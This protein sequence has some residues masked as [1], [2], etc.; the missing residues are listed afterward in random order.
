MDRRTEISDHFMHAGA[1][2]SMVFAWLGLIP[3]VIPLVALTAVLVAV[4]AL[5]LAALGLVAVVIAGPP[6]AGWRL[7]RRLGF[8]GGGSPVRV[9]EFEEIAEAHR[10]MESS[11]A[12]G[13]LVIRGA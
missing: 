3:G 2:T 13:K 7:V 10:V 12:A 1:G 9:F 11:Q 6:Y 4:L 5:P 8:G